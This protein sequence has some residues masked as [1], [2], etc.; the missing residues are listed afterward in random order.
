MKLAFS[1]HG[2][3]TDFSEGYELYTKRS[4]KN[5]C[6]DERVYHRVIRSYCRMLSRRLVRDGCVDLPCELGT[7]VAAEITRKPK[8]IGKKFIGYGRMDWSAGRYDGT[9]KTFGLVYLPKHGKNNNLRCFGFV[10]NRQLFKEMKKAHED[11]ECD[12]KLLEFNDEM[13]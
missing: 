13:I 12:W 3:Y 5:E 11:R 10:A 9:L 4:R 2:Q 7:I 6:F 8:Y 1:G